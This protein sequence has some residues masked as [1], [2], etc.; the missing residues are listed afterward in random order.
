MN[1]VH[2]MNYI[3]VYVP[4]NGLNGVSPGSVGER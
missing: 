2:N 1:Y 3:H 4:K